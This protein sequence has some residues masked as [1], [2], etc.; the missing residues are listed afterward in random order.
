MLAAIRG[1]YNIPRDDNLKLRDFPTL[2]HVIGFVY[3]KRP[4]LA[5]AKAVSRAASQLHRSRL[6]L[7]RLL[8]HPRRWR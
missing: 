5:E 6:R 8:P 7:L 2:R 4:D 1:M 3:S